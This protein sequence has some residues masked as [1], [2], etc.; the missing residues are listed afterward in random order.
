MRDKDIC[1]ELQ[2]RVL[3]DPPDDLRINEYTLYDVLA[4]SN[5]VKVCTCFECSERKVMLSL[6][7]PSEIQYYMIRKSLAFIL[8]NKRRT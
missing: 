3:I 1:K 6:H 7:Y 4:Y 2:L 8:N 5:E